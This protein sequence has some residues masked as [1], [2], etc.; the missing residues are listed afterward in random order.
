MSE[1]EAPEGPRSP[2]NPELWQLTYAAAQAFGAAVDEVLATRSAEPR[3]SR[4][5]IGSSD[6]GWPRIEPASAPTDEEGPINVRSLVGSEPDYSHPIGYDGVAEFEAL[7]EYV[8]G[9][10]DLRE[11]SAIF[12]NRPD[13][14]RR[15]LF[16][17]EVSDL[18]LSILDRGRAL[19]LPDTADALLPLYLEREAAWLR[20]SLE[21]EYIVPLVL[22]VLD[23][24]ERIVLDE[25]HWIEP[26]S[27]E[28]QISRLGNSLSLS[29]VVDPVAD[30]ANHAL[31]LGGYQVQN[32]GPAQRLLGRAEPAPPYADID[33]A[34]Q[35]LRIVTG[36]STGYAHILQR[37]LGW[38]DHWI[39]D[40]PPLSMVAT[41]RRYPDV[42]DDYGWL[43]PKT[44]V[45]RSDLDRLPLVFK[46]LRS[47]DP[48]VKLAARRL[49]TAT[50]R[51]DDDDKTI[52][53]CIGLEALLGNDRDELTHRYSQRAAAL[54]A[55]RLRDPLDPRAIYSIM[56]RVYSHRSVV[57]HGMSGNKTRKT[58]SGGRTFL[59]SDLAVL[60]L[61]FVLE[62]ALL[63]PNE[64]TPADL[65]N[66]LLDSLA[67]AEQPDDDGS[68]GTAARG[69]DI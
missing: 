53:A 30:A 31:V 46:S 24:E 43:R 3:R 66:L 67:V 11:R 35:A 65:D 64:W 17:F 12:A 36:A 42:F 4:T 37:P 26:M 16:R 44:R 32:P 50:T 48:N 19:G 47:A 40:R 52:D 56:K 58:E 63:R 38:A 54:L 15:T 33:V 39:G 69:G 45:E 21:V 55:T 8:W 6:T 22:T 34:F 5:R 13:D 29:G 14:I 41:V 51:T 28:T 10:A 57:A 49:S 23:L 1:A 68:E 59:T 27:E 2:I 7:A 20:E 25:N 61:R 9:D 60:L 62:E 18:V